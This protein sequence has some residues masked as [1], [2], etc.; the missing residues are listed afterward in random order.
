[1]T[2]KTDLTQGFCPG[3]PGDGGGNG[4]GPGGGGL[5]N[6][7]QL[8]RDTVETQARTIRYLLSNYEGLLRK[9]EREHPGGGGHPDGSGNVIMPNPIHIGSQPPQIEHFWF[10]TANN[11][12]M[13]WFW[14]AA[15][16]VPLDPTVSGGTVPPATDGNS[17]GHLWLDA[18]GRLWAW[19]GIIWTEIT[20]PVPGAP[21]PQAS[22]PIVFGFAPPSGPSAGNLWLDPRQPTLHVWTGTQ[23]R[24]IGVRPPRRVR[25]LYTPGSIETTG[26]WSVGVQAGDLLHVAG[27]RGIDPLTNLQIAIPFGTEGAAPNNPPGY[28]RVY[29]AFTNLKH[30]VEAEG[31][32]LFDT[33]RLQ[34]FLTNMA[35]DRPIV[36][37]I[38]A[39]PEFWGHGPYP[40]RTILAVAQLNGSD[41][42]SEWLSPDLGTNGAYTA[43][44]TPYSGGMNARARGDICEAQATLY[45]PQYRSD[46]NPVTHDIVG[47]IPGAFVARE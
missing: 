4:D 21:I 28:Q 24:T 11:M 35:R 32:T 9:V 41:T 5:S 44:G 47:A 42:L 43:S 36:N 14:K 40:N 16:F 18:T 26:T 23:W 10:D 37:T 6:A 30:I 39:L 1:M 34:V 13:M 12:M 2:A 20:Y 17:G 38:Q 22:A 3:G 27:M 25:V 33:V 15:G 8:C 31:C 45:A 46:W 19:E 7:L 29:Q